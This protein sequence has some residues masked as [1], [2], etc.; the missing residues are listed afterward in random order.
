M[1]IPQEEFVE[2][3]LA[4]DNDETTCLGKGLMIPHAILREGTEIKGVL[5]LS[6]EGVNLESPDGERV[7]A[8]LLL[9]TPET[10]RHRH[11]QVLAAFANLVTHDVKFREQLYHD[12]SPAHAY[13]VLHHKDQQDLNYFLE[14]AALRVGLRNPKEIF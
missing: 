11:L 2:L 8:I 4:R 5:G 10:D 7:H 13:D 6:S 14:D 3:V 1:E 9:A 12:R